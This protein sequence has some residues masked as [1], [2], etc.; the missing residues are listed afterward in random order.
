M[1]SEPLLSLLRS[2]QHPAA[3]LFAQ[4]SAALSNIELL[5]AI[6]RTGT[7]SESAVHLATRILTQFNG[8]GGL[9]QASAEE[10]QGVRDLGSD[11]IAQIAAALELGRRISGTRPEDRP[12][13]TSA[14]DAALYIA[15]MAAL[16]QEHV[17]V[18]LLDS[19]R[20]V[21]AVPTLYIGTLN[22]SVLRVSEVFREAITRNSP[23]LI[24]AHNH[25][26]GDP[27]PSPEDV[28]LTRTLASAGRLLDITL[29]DHV[30]IGRGSWVSL[31]DQGFL[32]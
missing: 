1:D 13:I 28:E 3:R 21:T 23:A 14:A 18:I 24:L 15:D 17:R 9:A 12:V 27:T 30:I 32:K 20:R 2:Y 26:S 29:V 25:P 5:A 10:L 8:L 16:D 11:K 7:N 31:R 22:A 4:G 19:A 6:L